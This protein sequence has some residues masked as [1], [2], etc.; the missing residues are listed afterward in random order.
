MEKS[1]E[2]WKYIERISRQTRQHR[3][4]LNRVYEQRLCREM[5][6]LTEQ[7]QRTCSHLKRQGK[8]EEQRQQLLPITFKQI[9]RE[10]QHP[11]IL[12]IE[13]GRYLS[14]TNEILFHLL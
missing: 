6:H 11:L 13:N 10:R 2:Q 8:L 4:Q 5:A 14:N 1:I 9:A 7:H 3:L 12:N